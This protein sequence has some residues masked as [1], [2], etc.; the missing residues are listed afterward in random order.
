MYIT[1][2]APN[3]RSLGATNGLA[4]M[5]AS[6]VRAIGPA[7]STSMF[8]YSVQH[9]LMGGYAVYAVLITATASSVML[10]AK[11]PESIEKKV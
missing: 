10:S 4:Q 9:K 11:L 5:T 6:I 3:K 1:A 7:A 8:A 2:A